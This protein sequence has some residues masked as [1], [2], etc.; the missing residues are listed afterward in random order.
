MAKHFKSIRGALPRT[1]AIGASRS[2]R[3]EGAFDTVILLITASRPLPIPL[4]F[5]ARIRD[6]SGAVW[7]W[8]YT[9]ARTLNS[10]PAEPD[11][12]TRLIYPYTTLEPI[13]WIQITND[14]GETRYLYPSLAGQPQTATVQPSGTGVTGSPIVL[15]DDGFLYTIGLTI[16]DTHYPINTFLGERHP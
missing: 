3:L 5:F 9:R 4:V 13:D 6:Q 10:T 1:F 12:L 16:A 8:W 7:W 11:L 15:G 14:G 2:P